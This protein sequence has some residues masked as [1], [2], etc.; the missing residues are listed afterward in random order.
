MA[1]RNPDWNEDELVLALDLYLSAKPRDLQKRSP[2][3]LALSA[4][5]NDLHRQLGTTGEVTLRNPAG[6]YMKLQNLK[7][8]DPEYLARGHR[9][10]KAGNQLEQVLWT[11]YC[12]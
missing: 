12:D 6:V 5:L 11:R 10:L 9:G 8:H 2:E 3:V 7:A 1:T 4:L